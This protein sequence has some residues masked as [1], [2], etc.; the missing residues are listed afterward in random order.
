MKR[1]ISQDGT[2]I[3]FEQSGTGP[4]MILVDGALAYRE[5]FGGRPLAAELSKDFTVITY[6]RRGRGESTDAQ[7]YAV[8]R[9]IEDIEALT[10]A[11]G[12]PVYLYGFSSGSVLA[13]RAAAVLR[14][15]VAGLALHEPPFNSDDEKAKQEFAEFTRHMAELLAAGRRGEAVAFFFADM[16]L[17]EMIEDMKQ[18][19]EWSLMEAVAHT[20]AYDNAVFGDGA[21][22]VEVASGATMPTLILAGSESQAFRH[23]AAD[24]LAKAMPQAERKI[25]E[26][27]ETLVP[28]AILAPV[29]KGFFTTG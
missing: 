26:G 27:Q 23:E 7:P 25:L 8:E 13:L 12:S 24:T 5:H 4:A 19:P 6:D 21:V 16:L 17:P 14:D 3:A 20:L 22:P 9:E 18:S 10:D 28:P 11:A 2:S 15:K 1:V 29:L